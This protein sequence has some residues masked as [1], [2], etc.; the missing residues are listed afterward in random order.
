MKLTA[1]A[2]RILPLLALGLAGAVAA[3]VSR[4]GDDVRFSATLSPGRR[5]LAG[6]NQL[7]ADNVAVI[8]GL[9]RQDEA[10]SKFKHNQVDDT[11]FSQRRT[12]RE[13]DLAG[14]DRLT[15]AQLTQLDSFVGERIAGTA[16]PPGAAIGSVTSSAVKPGVSRAPLDIHG[17]ISVTYGWGKGGSVTGGSVILD[18]DDP[19]ERYSVLFGY[20][21]YRGKGL[22]PCYYPGRDPY[23]V[24]PF[25]R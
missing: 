4:G 8:D 13:R 18:Y 21:E 23:R 25:S 9:V 6:L 22:L 10:A 7:T 12:A 1:R 15:P 5:E 2:F 11:R 19:A 24:G 3:P 20:A 14:L 17:E 16:A